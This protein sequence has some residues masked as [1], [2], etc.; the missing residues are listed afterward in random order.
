MNK[1]LLKNVFIVMLF[2]LFTSFSSFAVLGK[3]AI[4]EQPGLYPQERQ[5]VGFFNQTNNPVI[6]TGTNLIWQGNLVPFLQ[7]NPNS[8]FYLDITADWIN[9]P[10][11]AAAAYFPKTYALNF[12]RPG[13][14]ALFGITSLF[15]NHGSGKL[16]T[17]FTIDNH[18]KTFNFDISPYAD[19]LFRITF[20][21]D[22]T[23]PAGNFEKTKFELQAA[24]LEG[25]TVKGILGKVFS[26]E[27]ESE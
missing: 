6:I 18:T 12:G 21:D 4:T 5:I 17:I 3:R 20:R 24:V 9:N 11:S 19:L 27:E 23:K 14:A 8:S 15:I 25:K 7:L 26:E 10:F 1:K 22:A 2:S 13:I 16:Q